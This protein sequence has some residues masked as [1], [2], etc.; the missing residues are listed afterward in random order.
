MKFT[1]LAAVALVGSVY[2]DPSKP[3]KGKPS[4]PDCC[5]RLSS[6]VPT[7]YYPP[8]SPRYND[9]INNR[10]SGNSI[11]HPSCV[12]APKSAQDVSKAL[13]LLS[14]YQCRF[15]VKGG[16]HNPNPGANSI[17]NGVS[18]D[19][20]GLDSTV[21][22]SDGSHVSLGAGGSWG[23]AYDAFNG[24]DIGF[25]GALCRD[26]SVGAVALGGGS[27]IFQA[28]K[29]WV[30]DQILNYEVVL[31]SGR[32]VNANGSHNAD[33]FRALKGGFTNLAIVTKIDLAAF[34]FGTF[35]DSEVVL[36]LNGP[37]ANKSTM[38][39]IISKTA[40]D[41]T[42]NNAK[43]TANGLHV[44]VTSVAKNKT[45]LA[46]L[47]IT[48]TDNKANPPA[49]KPIRSVPNQ[50][51]NVERHGKISGYVKAISGFQPK[52]FRQVTASI[53]IK[54][55]Y[56]TLR[57]IWDASDAV[58]KATPQNDKIA[59]IVELY[60]QPAIMQSHASTRGGNMLGL[61]Q[62]PHDRIVIWLS[63]RW[64]DASLDEMMQKASREFT[65]A[66]EAVARKHGTLD[67]F[68]YVNFAGSFQS[69]LCGYGP[70]NVAHLR[71][72][73]AKYDPR[74]VFQRLMSG[75]FKLREARCRE[76]YQ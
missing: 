70:D 50:R 10:W 15:A 19:L 34:K 61:S 59:W 4:G 52:G 75:G 31:S 26:V 1:C 73:A 62:T 12:V 49:A 46:I 6:V 2:G 35:W 60:P 39:D 18:I 43:D 21:L 30:V 3:A 64:K 32:I 42:A 22:A 20:G 68:V 76:G 5:R 72:M 7:I 23:H 28:R 38:L 27:S 69:P 44:A 53:T 17:D 71:R 40:V 33:L 48:N 8:T 36:S 65:E 45:D 25:P 58:Y 57:E 14:K 67:P 11:L 9:L 47:A 63:S 29:G 13:R 55:D 16:G 51:A 37:Q 66:V 54:N 56:Q 74:G 24:S 41:F